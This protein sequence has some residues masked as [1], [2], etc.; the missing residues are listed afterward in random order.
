MPVWHSCYPSEHVRQIKT[1][2]DILPDLCCKQE[3]FRSCCYELPV[4]T[5]VLPMRNKHPLFLKE[6]ADDVFTV[7]DREVIKGIIDVHDLCD[8]AVCFLCNRSSGSILI[9]RLYGFCKRSSGMDTASCDFKI[10]VLFCKF[11]V[12]LVS[13]R[14]H[15]TG[16]CLQ[17]FPWMIRMTGRLPVK[18]DNG[19][20]SA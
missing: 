14:D 9:D 7:C 17:E 8:H 18:E 10:S 12:E 6:Q 4:S 20:G 19:V 11:M 1:H 2:E 5:F 15:S 16:E 13:V 3:P